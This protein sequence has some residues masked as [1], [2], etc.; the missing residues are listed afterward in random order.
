MGDQ[1]KHYIFRHEKAFSMTFRITHIILQVFSFLLVFAVAIIG[2]HYAMM[3]CSFPVTNEKASDYIASFFQIW[4]SCVLMLFVFKM[5]FRSIWCWK[6]GIEKSVTEILKKS[7]L[8]G[9]MATA[10]IYCFYFCLLSNRPLTDFCF[11]FLPIYIIL[12]GFRNIFQ[13]EI[14]FARDEQRLRLLK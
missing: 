8:L 13:E 9:L 10:F 1:M 3:H 12:E 11:C 14:Y 7:V 6:T 5:S 2:T 4:F